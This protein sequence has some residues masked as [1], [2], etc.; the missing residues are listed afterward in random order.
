MKTLGRIILIVVGGLMIYSAIRGFMSSIDGIK[1]IGGWQALLKSLKDASLRQ[2]TMQYLT[3]LLKSSGMIIV[4]ASAIFAGIKGHGGFWFSIFSVVML[5]LFIYDVV[6]KTKAG[7]FSGK[8]KWTHIWQLII[9][10]G[11]Q[12]GYILGFIFLKLGKNK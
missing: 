4:S 3:N 11:T 1:Q 9:D 2:T 8:D 12:I 7:T 10:S 6:G 5:G